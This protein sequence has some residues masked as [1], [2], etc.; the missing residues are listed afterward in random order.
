M[1]LLFISFMKTSENNVLSGLA[2]PLKNKKQLN[3]YLVISAPRDQGSW[4]QKYAI[5]P[6]YPG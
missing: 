5:S 2:K 1:L 3:A 4:T 6:E